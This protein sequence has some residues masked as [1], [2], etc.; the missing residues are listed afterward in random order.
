MLKSELEKCRISLDET[1]RA[2]DELISKWKQKSDLITEL[3]IKVKKMKEN[4]DQKEKAIEEKCKRLQDENQELNSKLRKIDDGFRMQYDAEKK[5]HLLQLE[6]VKHEYE[7][8][9]AAAY[10]KCK[11]LE[12]EMRAVLLE[13]ENKK[14]FYE[15][16]INNFSKLFSNFQAEIKQ[17]R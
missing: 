15:E 16:K 3:E 11:E 12:D 4:F 13:S 14:K 6:R 7:E 5:E 8:R 10:Q 2:Y 17:D 9:L 1:K